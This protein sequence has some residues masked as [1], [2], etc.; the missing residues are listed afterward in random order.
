MGGNIF[1]RP[2]RVHSISA[3]LHLCRLFL[4]LKCNCVGSLFPPTAVD[5]RDKNLFHDIRNWQW[6]VQLPAEIRCQSDIRSNLRV[7]VSVSNL[8]RNTVCG[9]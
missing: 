7:K 1:R 8:P 9:T 5:G 4:E 3:Y 6:N 2:L